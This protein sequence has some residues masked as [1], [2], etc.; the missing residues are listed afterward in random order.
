MKE[1]SFYELETYTE[2]DID[3][4]IKNEVEENIH[5]DYKRAEALSKDNKAI[6]EISKDV[7]AFANSDGGI[8]IYGLSEENHKPKER[9]F[10]DGSIFTKEWLETK[11]LDNIHQRIDGLIIYPIRNDG[12][13]RKTIYVV[14]IPRSDSAPHMAIDHKYYLRHNFSSIPMEEYQ[15]REVF[16]RKTIPSLELIDCHFYKS[17]D[18]SDKVTYDFFASI[19]NNGRC[20]CGEY[21]L[22][23]YLN[24]FEFCHFSNTSFNPSERL[25]PTIFNKTRFKLSFPAKE[26]I[27]QGEFL[28]IGHLRIDMPKEKE[29]V[30][31][32]KIVIDMI[33]FFPGG[34]KEIVYIPSSDKYLKEKDEIDLLMEKIS[35]D[36]D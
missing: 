4:L 10:V 17:D 33:L 13:I 21:K 6:N 30:V 28:D 19:K 25:S 16:N 9:S 3:Y 8:I 22:N 14:K 24:E 7:S 1:K 36:Y 11:I 35:Q 12:D 32:Q 23:V 20:A 15:V 34:T 2:K 18:K 26:M 5:L 31:F 27:F 29:S